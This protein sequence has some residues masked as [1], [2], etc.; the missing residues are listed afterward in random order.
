VVHCK[1]CLQVLSHFWKF[2]KVKKWCNI[3]SEEDFLS[4][5]TS[6]Q[7]S[8]EWLVVHVGIAAVNCC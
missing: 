4:L 5:Y 8:R 3:T 7:G 1:S 2:Q 6:K